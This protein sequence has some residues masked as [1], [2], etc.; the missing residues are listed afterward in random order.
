MNFKGAVIVGGIGILLVS[1]WLLQNNA[2]N[3]PPIIDDTPAVRDNV[4]TDISPS[5]KDT[6]TVNDSA[7]VNKN[8]DFLTDKNGT[9][10]YIINATD[11]PTLG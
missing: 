3:T 11:M 9:K 10:H 5:M 2:R 1:V 8:L 7:E 4:L 6:M